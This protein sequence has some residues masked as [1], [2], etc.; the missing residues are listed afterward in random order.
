MKHPPGRDQRHCVMQRYSM[1][2]PMPGNTSCNTSYFPLLKNPQY[3]KLEYLF[4]PHQSTVMLE[5]STPDYKPRLKQHTP[6]SIT[7]LRGRA[8]NG[9]RLE[10]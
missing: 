2:H 6:H 5:F 8:I 9:M 3:W 4:F 1:L 7:L 10:L